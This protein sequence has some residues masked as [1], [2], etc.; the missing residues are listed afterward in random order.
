MATHAEGIDQARVRAAV[1]ELLLAIGEDPERDG[2]RDT[3]AR[4]GRLYAEVFSGLHADPRLLLQKTFEVDHEEMVLQKDIEFSS[5]CEH[6]LLPFSGR[7]H[8]A[9][10]PTGRVVGLSKLARAVDVVARK[11]QIQERLT[12]EIADLMNEELAPRGVLVVIES[13]HTC[14]TVRGVRKPGTVCV[15]SAARGSTRRTRPRGPRSWDTFT[16]RAGRLSRPAQG[17]AV[18]HRHPPQA[19]IRHDLRREFRGEL[20][21]DPASWPCIPPTPACSKS[22]RSRLPI[23]KDEAR[24]PTIRTVCP[25]AVDSP[26]APRGRTGI[27][28]EALGPGRRHRPERSLPLDPR[29]SART[30][31][32]SSP[33][34]SSSG[35]T[36]LAKR[37]AGSAPDPASGAA[38]RR[39]DDRNRRSGRPRGRARLTRGTTSA[40]CASIWDD[41]T[42]DHYPQPAGSGPTASTNREIRAQGVTDLDR[43]A[44]AIAAE[45]AADAVQPGRLRSTTCHADGPDYP[46]AR[47]D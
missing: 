42:A 45:P 15:T 13:V 7:A 19:R 11:P 4:V 16:V 43:H 1:R 33:G 2:L 40:A 35:S 6:H 44:G 34:S 3:P 18:G 47:G 28:G 31:C 22:S 23:P 41:G 26:V 32:A 10:L 46:A 8:V 12:Q 24:P 27:A 14:M 21:V 20:L 25:R 37:A 36:R 38:V 9:Y 17:P 29:R 39:R 30:G 5:F